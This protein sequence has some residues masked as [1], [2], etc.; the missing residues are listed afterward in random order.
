[1]VRFY[2]Q[3][4]SLFFLL[5]PHHHGLASR[6]GAAWDTRENHSLALSP[7]QNQ[8]AIGTYNGVLRVIDVQSGSA[9]R[10]FFSTSAH[11]QGV[12]AVAFSPD[13]TN[14][15][16]GSYDS[17]ICVTDASS[18]RRLLPLLEGH[19]SMITVVLYVPPDG[20]RIISGS[21]DGTLRVWRAWS[22]EPLGR[23]KRDHLA[24]IT[25]GACSP[26]G[27]LFASASQD[28]MIIIWDVIEWDV[29]LDLDYYSIDLPNLQHVMS[30]KA[31]DRAGAA[32]SLAFSLD[33]D[34]LASG[35]HDKNIY[36]WNTASGVLL[37]RLH[38]HMDRV[39]CM[40]FS[41]DG[42]CLVSGSSDSTVRVWDRRKGTLTLPPLYEHKDGVWTVTFSSDGKRIISSS[43]DGTLHTWNAETG[44][45]LV[46]QLFRGH[47][48][49]IRTAAFSPN[50]ALIASGSNDSTVR[51]WN[52]KSGE[53]VLQ[54]LVGH[55]AEVL[56]V[57]F[58]PDG[59][60]IASGSTDETIR[61]WNTETGMVR[62]VEPLRGH[63]GAITT[64][65]FSP[66]GDRIASGSRDCTIRLWDTRIGHNIF[67][68]LRGHQNE[69]TRVAFAPSGETIISSSTDRTIRIWDAM[70]GK[71]IERKPLRVIMAT[72]V[73]VAFSFTR[74]ITT[75]IASV[76]RDKS[77][78]IWTWIQETNLE[79]SYWEERRIWPTAQDT[80]S[81]TALA[82]SPEGGY[83]VCGLSDRTVRLLK[84]ESEMEVLPPLQGH[85][86]L[87]SAVE[88]S[89]DGTR[90]LSASYDK[91]IHVWNPKTGQ[92]IL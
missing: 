65:A 37:H 38:G 57:S 13:G 30:F 28:G 27:E 7:E 34:M 89:N 39:N 42:D 21:H 23:P 41:P 49:K 84:I 25:S 62:M 50:G 26:N 79:E 8:L 87:I 64:I 43:I 2:T 83:I 29:Y 40:A 82:F 17:T 77:I 22:G 58:S 52:A 72:M 55:K 54:P 59:K 19:T 73:P 92:T 90:I 20:A 67:D 1:M 61:L 60:T 88:F 18:G 15:V 24:A 6:P 74:A 46:H 66:N 85:T 68:S 63:E 75:R 70:L 36:I 80:A 45:P 10:E 32:F 9:S 14:V 31:P 53:R 44:V 86:G 11:T 78:L 16:S 5:T 51:V 3:R 91:T 4:R 81:P 47:V 56:C 33:G 35:F 12:T 69:V 48:D 71:E 76:G